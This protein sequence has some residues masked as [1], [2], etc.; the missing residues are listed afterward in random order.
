MLQLTIGPTEIFNEETNKLIK[1]KGTTLQ[2][3]HSLIS[4]S[5]WEEKWHKA[6]LGKD[7]KTAEET[8]DYVR[9]M[10]LTQNVDPNVYYALT[11]E[12]FKAISAYIEDSHTATWFSEDRQKGRPNRETITS[13][14][15]Y[16]WMVQLNIPIDPFQKWHLNRLMTLIKVINIKNTP[17]KKM[18][19]AEQARAARNRTA[20]NEARRAQMGSKG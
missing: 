15:I 7:N 3:E 6:F 10:T 9:C 13:E 4:V 1:V 14:L 16:C 12:D 2:L 8:I 18:S 20:L 5:K 17:P 19:R 11:P